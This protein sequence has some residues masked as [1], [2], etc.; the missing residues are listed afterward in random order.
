MDSC[1]PRTHFCSGASDPCVH[2]SLFPSPVCPPSLPPSLTASVSLCMSLSSP[3]AFSVPSLCVRDGVM[4]CGLAL[5]CCVILKPSTHPPVQVSRPKGAGPPHGKRR[6]HD[7]KGLANGGVHLQGVHAEERIP[8]RPRLLGNEASLCMCHAHAL[9][10]AHVKRVS[11]GW[12]GAGCSA[13]HEGGGGGGPKHPTPWRCSNP[14]GRCLACACAIA[15][16][17]PPNTCAHVPPTHL[18]GAS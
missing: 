3:R 6:L 5:R 7:E 17:Q 10:H 9:V 8:H 14:V 2:V 4:W 1:S 12:S 13:P 15:L 16:S 11:W 18:A